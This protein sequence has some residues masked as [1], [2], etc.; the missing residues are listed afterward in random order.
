MKKSRIF[1]LIALLL[2]V[3]LGAFYVYKINIFDEN[4]LKTIDIRT[5]DFTTP[6]VYSLERDEAK[7]LL[8]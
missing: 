6:S 8:G 5:G 4:T 3:S 7:K 2:I 1:I